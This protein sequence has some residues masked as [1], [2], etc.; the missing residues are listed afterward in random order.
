M[1]EVPQKTYHCGFCKGRHTRI[2]MVQQCAVDYY[3][4]T[5][6]PVNVGLFGE[7]LTMVVDQ[8]S[9]MGMV[10]A[11]EKLPSGHYLIPV[12]T[13][14][15]V[16]GIHAQ[17]RRPTKG[18][19]AGRYFISLW[20]TGSSVPTAVLSQQD[21]D[22]VVKELLGGNWQRAMLDY[23]RTYGICPVCEGALSPQELK[24]G[25]NRRQECYDVIY[26]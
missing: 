13:A 2:E 11:T 1:T 6:K 24:S 12:R 25:V 16:V 3:Q 22:D 8:K 15:S 19:W 14:G 17:L 5:G 20:E 23:G 7:N 10:R 4:K 18:K 26:G 9:V 21:R